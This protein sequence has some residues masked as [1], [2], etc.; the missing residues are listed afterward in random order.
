MIAQE[1]TEKNKRMRRTALEIM[2]ELRISLNKSISE[3]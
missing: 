2:L 1:N 3:P